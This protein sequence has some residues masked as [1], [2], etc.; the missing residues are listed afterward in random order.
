MNFKSVLLGFLTIREMSGYEMKALIDESVGFFFGATYGSIY[1]AVRDLEVDGFVE[2][3]II[4]Q[5]D[6]PNKN[7]YRITQA[8]RDYLKDQLRTPPAPD[9]FRSE[10][11]IRLFFGRHI[12]PTQ[13]LEWISQDRQI[14]QTLLNKLRETERGIP[15]HETFERMCLGFGLTY[16]TST[17]A[18][19]DE[20]EAQVRALADGGIGVKEA[21]E[22]PNQRED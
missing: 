22:A 6:R 20:V 3:T 16:Y 18:W 15:E 17:L 13:L 4:I 11:L 1:P 8:G 7:V 14:R 2:K 9:N 5:H 21:E 19:L 12:Q 10:F